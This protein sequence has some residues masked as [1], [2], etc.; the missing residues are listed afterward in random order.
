MEYESPFAGKSVYSRADNVLTSGHIDLI[1]AEMS[2]SENDLRPQSEHS[3]SELEE[4][5]WAVVSF[6][7]CEADRLTYRQA[8]FTLSELERAGVT[9]LCIVT[10][11]ASA[12][13]RS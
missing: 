7:R 8:A 1:S 10:T 5:R 13:L 11:E 12:R 2:V 4:P 3:I 9:G 6:E